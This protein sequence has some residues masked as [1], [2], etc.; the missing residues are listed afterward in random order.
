MKRGKNKSRSR[1]A[2]PA[3]PANALLTEDGKPLLTE[4]GK[5]ILT[6]S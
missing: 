6:E 4:D 5:Y 1:T 3:I 2:E